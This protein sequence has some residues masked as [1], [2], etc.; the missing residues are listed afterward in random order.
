MLEPLENLKN[1]GL[2]IAVLVS[3]LFIFASGLFFGIIYYVMDITHVSL[4]ATDCVITGNSLVSSCQELFNFSVYPFLVLRSFLV[5]L[6]FFFIFG[7]I[8][9]LLILGYKSG[10]SSVMLGVMVAFLMVIT[11]GGILLSNIYR[12]L[13]SNSIVNSMMVPFTV[14]NRIMLNFPWFIFVVGL[15]SLTLALINFQKTPVN[16][17][18]P[19]SE[20]AY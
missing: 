5:Y 1:K 16:K 20:L 4:L 3:M 10:E 2:F 17:I 15:F 18:T 14:Y 6:S 7:L 11:Y 19:A 8:L 9:S 13:I 12:D